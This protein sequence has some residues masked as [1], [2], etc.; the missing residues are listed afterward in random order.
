MSLRFRKSFKL[1]PGLRLNMSKSG[2]GLSVGPRGASMSFGPS[3]TYRNI[4]LPGG[5]SLRDRV[6]GTSQRHSAS[7]SSD[8]QKV[9]VTVRL[10]LQDD[11][12]VIF[13]DPEG[14]PLAPSLQE[15]AKKQQGETIKAWLAKNCEEIN[16][17]I[18]QLDAIHVATSAPWQKPVY[19]PIPFTNEP[20]DLPS[21]QLLGLWGHVFPWVKRRIET[22]NAT[23]DAEYE[24]RMTAWRHVKTT[25]EHAEAERRTLL[26]ERLYREPEAMQL[27]L[28]QRLAGI[29]WPRETDI[30]IE[31]AEGG[32][33]AIL[34]VDLPEIED[35][36]RK[37]ATYGGRGWKVSI[38]ELSEQKVTQLYMRHVH[39][40]AFRVVG[41]TLAALP[42]VQHVVVSGHSQRSNKVTGMIT[43]EYLYS[44]KVSREQWSKLNFGNLAVLD[45]TES[46]SQFDLRRDMSKSGRFTAIEPFV[47]FAA[48]TGPT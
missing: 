5:F 31:I 42:T 28:E 26:E 19:T 32:T 23:A 3:G 43:D 10:G 20:P 45:V 47:R 14:H 17:K 27:V 29:P 33:V 16:E 48:E 38:K 46:L 12:T 9:S 36:P 13:K 41:E 30:A 39:G 25:Y 7:H 15:I 44:V 35:V 40:I 8:S 24:E 18:E 6:G 2:F 1:A 4:N 22:A 37:T 34:D 11:G 21:P